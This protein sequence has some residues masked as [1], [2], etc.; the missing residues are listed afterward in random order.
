[1]TNY[2]H[3]TAFTRSGHAAQSRGMGGVDA[4]MHGLKFLSPA[5]AGVVATQ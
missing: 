3:M 1:M 5:I 4:V 2:S